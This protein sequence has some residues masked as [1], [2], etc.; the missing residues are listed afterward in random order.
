MLQHY[1]HLN[2]IT[3]TEVE[4]L[5]GLL[6][7][8]ASISRAWSGLMTTPDALDYEDQLKQVQVARQRSPRQAN[9]IRHRLGAGRS[10]CGV[11]S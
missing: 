4:K 3:V 5:N 1:V 8:G 9:V 6:G 10:R 7:P 11:A 2:L